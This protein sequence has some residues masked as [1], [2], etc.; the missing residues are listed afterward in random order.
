MY[1]QLFDRPTTI[2]MSAPWLY[3]NIE[4]LKDDPKLETAMSLLIAYATNKRAMGK[5]NKRCITVLDECWSLL[6]SP[7]L[8]PVV[9][10]LFRTARKRNA[11]VWG[12]SHAVEDFTGTPEK[13]N[14][15]GGA[16]LTTTATKLLGRQKGNLDVL[17]KFVHLNET[18]ID[19]VKH[20]GMTEK[21]KKSEFLIVIGEKSET[22]HSLHIV[23][24]PIEYWLLTTFAREKW[25]RQYWLLKYANLTT[26]EAY[27]RLAA[28][29]PNG[30]SSL[31]ELPEEKSGEVMN[32]ALGQAIAAHSVKTNIRVVEEVLQEA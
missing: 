5:N 13:P 30:L 24:T 23:T 32:V 19:R 2:D 18:A 7:S 31:D 10:Q 26:T 1:A 22:T 9:V 20:L 17:R 4:Q 28:T 11:C 27:E 3:F 6:Q 12:L 29:Y 16:I 8:G 21:G 14:D 15:F 25:Y